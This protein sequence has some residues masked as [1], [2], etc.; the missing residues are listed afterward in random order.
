MGMRP[1]VPD[2][3]DRKMYLLEDPCEC[4]AQDFAYNVYWHKR[5]C[6]SCRRK[7][8]IS[9]IVWEEILN[10]TGAADAKNP[11]GGE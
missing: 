6:V 4:G 7:E 1:I 2:E 9:P 10:E 11:K 5:I 3:L 8:K